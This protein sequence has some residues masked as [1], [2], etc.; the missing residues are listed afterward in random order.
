MK[1]KIFG[2]LVV[3]LLIASGLGSLVNASVFKK[4]IN[5]PNDRPIVEASLLDPPV[6]TGTRFLLKEELLYV[7][8]SGSGYVLNLRD[9]SGSETQL[10]AGGPG[11]PSHFACGDWDGDGKDDYV[12]VWD[13][14]SSESNIFITEADGG[15]E[16]W[17]YQPRVKFIDFGDWDGDGYDELLYIQVSG[18][19]YVLNLRDQ[20]GSE[21]Q[22]SAG[23]PG[24]PSHFA[25]GD[26]D[27]D[28]KDDYVTV[29]DQ[30]SSESNI[31]ITEADGG[32]EHWVYQP[33]VKF[34]D[35]GDWDGDSV[36]VEYIDYADVTTE[37]HPI[38]LLYH[39]PYKD[40]VNY[41][42][43]YSEYSYTHS[44]GTSGENSIGVSA[45]VGISYEAS[46]PML[47]SAKVGV[48]IES[49][50]TH[51]YGNSAEQSQTTGFATQEEGEPYVVV[52]QTTYR[53]FRYKII[54]G[55]NNGEYFAIDI[56]TDKPTKSVV[57]LSSYNS[58]C[59]DAPTISSHH[60]A[61]DPT[62]YTTMYQSD[63]ESD[64][65]VTVGEGDTFIGINFATQGWESL[66]LHEGVSLTA[67]INVGGFGMDFT[68]GLF[69]DKTH[70]ITVGEETHF[71]G[72]VMGI[73]SSIRDKFLYNY[74][75]YLHRDSSN[76]Y[77]IIDY[78]VDPNS[79]GPGFY[80]STPPDT[81]KT[82]GPSEGE[83]IGVDYCTFEWIGSDDITPPDYL[84]YQYK[85]DDD[86]WSSW[87][88]DTSKYYPGLYEGRHTFQVRTRDLNGNVDLSP[89][90]ISFYVDTGPQD[91]QFSYNPTS[92]NFGDVPDNETRSTTFE[93]W[94]SGGGT[95]DYTLSWDCGWVTV[96]P[97][98]GSSTGGHNTIT[99]NID[100][101]DLSLG[102][103]SC[104]ISISS[105]DGNG[106]FT[107]YVNVVERNP[108]L[109]YTPN[110]IDFGEHCIGWTGSETFEIW[111][112]GTGTLEFSLS[113]NIDWISVSPISGSSEDEHK[114]ITVNVINTGS[115]EVGYY[116]GDIDIMS[117]GGSG[118][119][120]VELTIAPETPELCYSP[121]LI[122]IGKKLPGWTGSETFEIWNCGTGTLEFSLSE[123]I[124]WISVSPISG[125]SEDEHK[126]I[127]VNVINTGSMEVG[128]YSGDIDIMSNGG[129]G[130]VHVE[131]EIGI[132]NTLDVVEITRPDG[133][134]YIGDNLFMSLGAINIIIGRIT[135][136]VDASDESG[137]DRV[138]FYIDDVKEHTDFSAPYEWTWT[139]AYMAKTKEIKAVAYDNVG[140]SD[141]NEIMVWKFF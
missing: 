89:A 44:G 13:Q 118:S 133:G 58:G 8:V 108:V 99:A 78:Y 110:T 97:T 4:P 69:N 47:L 102:P 16:H 14:G 20:S 113:E 80:D 75:M 3:M 106:V 24:Y 105:N 11:Y 126:T 66:S 9:Q 61:G 49:S 60:S 127:T 125:S 32:D 31:F 27:G 86:S 65:T 68:V 120:H 22:L 34:I 103:H 64:E 39:P 51:T 37:Y 123:N 90:T 70:T 124:D 29:W 25:C 23:G 96:S 88:S 52:E 132:D 98:S 109:D 85:M 72:R 10:S 18:S 12:T 53:Q 82:S 63:V 121:S 48:E 41:D 40:R 38:A 114:T 117:N 84:D 45:K 79:F 19:G 87:T 76:K 42:G 81:T 74:K 54:N 122:D 35:F 107:V 136:E 50:I 116:S 33:R 73:H 92:H 119:V 111:N 94:N 56:P 91:P 1:K 15:D 2:I 129:S 46:I 140:N 104:P 5:D 7:Q 100:T 59:T 141:S 6:R 17:V 112:C 43:S 128:Y 93:I 36:K 115:M 30:G 134:I 77:V 95:L 137:I 138:E 55:P 130:S 62:S 28:G 26:W 67:G 21:T 131:I 101:T 139:D 83:T 57:T 135:I 71:Y